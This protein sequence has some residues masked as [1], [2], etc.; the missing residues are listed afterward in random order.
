MH[1]TLG[2]NQDTQNYGQ[3]LIK[4]MGLKKNS[5]HTIRIET[6][7]NTVEA[8]IDGQTAIGLTLDYPEILEVDGQDLMSG[9][10]FLGWSSVDMA[11]TGIE[12]STYEP[13][14]PTTTTE[15]TTTEAT[16]TEALTTPEPTTI[17]TE[18]TTTE[19]GATT[20]S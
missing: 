8:Y 13:C 20:Q 17:Q 6:S 11:Y 12:Y 18:A 4:N 15:A 19:V 16:T 10:N 9:S 2:F 5:A 7:G 14:P 1:F 3:L